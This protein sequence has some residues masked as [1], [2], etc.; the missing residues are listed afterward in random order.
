[1]PGAKANAR[2]R[3][4]DGAPGG[5]AAPAGYGKSL[6]DRVKGCLKPEEHQILLRSD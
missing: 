3:P 4:L 5:V 2:T 1:M 6:Q